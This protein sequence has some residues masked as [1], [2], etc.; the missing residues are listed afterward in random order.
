MSDYTLPPRSTV[1]VGMTGSGKTTFGIRYLLNANPVCR[2]IFD[3]TGQMAARLRRP[4]ASTA[5]ELEAAL[6]TRWVIYNPHRMFPG[7]TKRAFLFFCDWAF[8]VSMRGRGHK[9]FFADE[10]WRWQDRDA[11]PM[12][13]AKISQM[14]RVENL[15]LV[16]LTQRPQKVNDS[17]TGSATELVCFKL[18]ESVQLR[19][20]SE[21]G[22]D[23]AAVSQLPLGKYFS[24][25]CVHGG[26]VTGRV[27]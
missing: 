23:A 12:E 22:A 16:T 20:I 27:F 1:I 19:K 10:I 9:I 7:D 18:T 3:D 17:I 25:D 13:L 15:E 8:K 11:I 4:H 6:A 24:H 5:N 21:L 14:G 26:F 2:F